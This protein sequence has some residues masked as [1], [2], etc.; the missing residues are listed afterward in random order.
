MGREREGW[1]QLPGLCKHIQDIFQPPTQH[2]GRWQQAQKLTRGMR[3]R[4]GRR[5][6]EREKKRK[7]HR[8][9]WREN[10]C[11]AGREAGPDAPEGS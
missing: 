2:L 3:H 8:E 4:A 11:R 10:A 6:R 5:Q 1:G 7:K 9:S